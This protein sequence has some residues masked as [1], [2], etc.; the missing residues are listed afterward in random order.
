MPPGPSVWATFGE[1]SSFVG[2]AMNVLGL[3]D[4]FPPEGPA[5]KPSD[6]LPKR[7]YEYIGRP[8]LPVRICADSSSEEI[9]A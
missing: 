1:L 4:A 5:A 3:G 7:K 8:P 6:S 9:S 2:G